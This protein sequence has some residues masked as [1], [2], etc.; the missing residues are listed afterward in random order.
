ML[1]G[2]VKDPLAAGSRT[3]VFDLGSLDYADSAGIGTI[4]ACLTQIKKAGG[5]MRV[6][7]A[8]PRLGRLFQM[9]GV[10]TLLSMYPSV[11]EAA[12]A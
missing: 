11:A 8:N 6:A 1:T 4:V 10:D 5:E 2:T 12:A 9:T 3:F 7:A